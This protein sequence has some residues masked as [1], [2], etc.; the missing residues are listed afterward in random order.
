VG[1]I[2][3]H[4][5]AVDDKRLSIRALNPDGSA[6]LPPARRRGGWRWSD[7]WINSHRCRTAPPPLGYI[8]YQTANREPLHDASDNAFRDIASCTRQIVKRN[9]IS[10]A[11]SEDIAS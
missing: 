10:H 9:H 7:L 8:P 6:S 1:S 11:R 5:G 2:Q 3:E 4:S